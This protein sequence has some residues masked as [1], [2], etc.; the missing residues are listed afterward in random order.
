MVN[1]NCAVFGCADSRY[2]L[3]KWGKQVCTEHAG[4]AKKDCSCIPPFTLHWFPSVL[5]NGDRRKE[6]IRLVNRTTNRGGKW[7]PGQSDMVCSEHFVDGFPTAENPNPTIKLGYE[8]PAKKPRQEPQR[9][10]KAQAEECHSTVVESKQVSQNDHDYYCT[11]ERC[12]ACLD[13]NR[14]MMSMACEISQLTADKGELEDEVECLRESVANLHFQ[15]KSRKP[16]SNSYIRTDEK[17]KF[18]T[19]IQ[20][21]TIFNILWSFL[22]PHFPQLNYWRGAKVLTSKRR[23]KTFPRRK[24]LSGRD[25]FLLVLMKLRLALLNQDLADRFQ[26]SPGTCSSIFTTWVKFLSSF[27]GNALIVWLPKEVIL[28]NLPSFFKGRNKK[29]RCIIDCTEI[30][31]ERPKSLDVQATTWSDY[32]KHNTFK[33]LVAVSPAG[34]IMFL[35]DCFGGRATDQFICQES[36]FYNFLEQGDIVM[37][38]RG[39][40]IREDLLHY[41][42]T[43][44]IPPGARTKSQMTTGECRKTK[45]VANLRIHV[46]RAINRL[47][48]FRILKNTFPLTMLPLANDIVRLCAAI[49]N[50]QPPLIKG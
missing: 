13:K 21:I 11:S 6:W 16:F 40:Q 28:S 42:C 25:Q 5:K 3:R 20:S 24:K 35:S 37:A 47:K 49:C 30:Y 15:C 8:K 1:G 34:Y 48:T 23:P 38:D 43:L 44:A 50:I 4:L 2:T 17:M 45:E 46:E 39:F 12:S 41:Y 33:F 26:I 36:G 29:V 18:Y 14:V 10:R 19:G 32:K 22:K 27:L 7:S 31:I 9:K